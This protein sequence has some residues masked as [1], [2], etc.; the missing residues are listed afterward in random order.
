MEGILYVAHKLEKTLIGMNRTIEEEMRGITD[1]IV[2]VACTKR[3]IVKGWVVIM[4]KEAIMTES[5]ARIENYGFSVNENFLDLG[6]G[7][8]GPSENKH[9]NIEINLS[10]FVSMTL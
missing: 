10:I 2:N 5:G 6:K 1:K 8:E 4:C 9:E 3:R 7:Q